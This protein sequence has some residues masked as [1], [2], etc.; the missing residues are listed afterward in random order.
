MCVFVEVFVLAES[1]TTVFCCDCNAVY[2]GLLLAIPARAQA[3]SNL[4]KKLLTALPNSHYWIW[5]KYLRV[6]YTLL[7]SDW[8]VQNLEIEPRNLGRST[9]TYFSFSFPAHILTRMRKRGKILLARVTS[10]RQCVCICVG[11]CVGT[12]VGVCVFF[13]WCGRPCV[14]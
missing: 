14:C 3:T 4:E 13:R 1:F 8:L 5:W 7:Q 10:L 12:C 9:H 2:P 11:A 6:I